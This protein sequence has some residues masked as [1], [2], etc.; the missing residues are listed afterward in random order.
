MGTGEQH[1]RWCQVKG[2][3]GKRKGEKRD[4]L[5]C[6]SYRGFVGADQWPVLRTANTVLYSC[7]CPALPE[8]EMTLKVAGTGM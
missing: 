8:M 1:A 7:R 2:A 4:R 6:G 3:K 5:P